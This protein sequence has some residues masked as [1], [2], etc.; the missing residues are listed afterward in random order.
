MAAKTFRPAKRFTLPKGKGKGYN[1]VR[2][3]LIV[4]LVVLLAFTMVY[5]YN[6]H[7]M[8]VKL[9]KFTEI[10]KTKLTVVYI[11]SNSC[12]HC[13]KFSPIYDK[14]KQMDF[15][16]DARFANVEV[17]ME[18]KIEKDEADPSYMEY[19]DAFPT[20]LIFKDGVFQKKIVGSVGKDDLV[21]FIAANASNA[22]A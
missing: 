6:I 3:V 14:V 13:T 21:N 17:L 10:P 1:I 11:Y 2:Y 19:I 7:K 18:P 9:E 8:A 5:I 20:V 16:A 4:A 12:G 15:T 22:A